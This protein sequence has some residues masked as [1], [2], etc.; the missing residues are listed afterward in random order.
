YQYKFVD[1]A[2]FARI[3]AEDK[4]RFNHWGMQKI[5]MMLR[6]KGISPEVIEEALEVADI[7]NYQ[8][9]CEALLAQKMKTLK[10]Q[11]P[12][13]LKVK[14]FRFGAGRGFD[15]DTLHSCLQNLLPEG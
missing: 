3:Y 12:Y 11:D 9:E 15:F 7:R 14:L 4:F 8:E 6:R 13:E 2:R 1:D 5:V 10:E